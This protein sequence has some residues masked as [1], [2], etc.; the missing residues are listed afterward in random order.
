[1]KMRAWLVLVIAIALAGSACSADSATEGSA[2]LAAGQDA[3]ATNVKVEDALEP[4][5]V[6]MTAVLFDG[7]ADEFQH[8]HR[9]VAGHG[10]SIRDGQVRGVVIVGGEPTDDE[11]RSW[12]GAL[13]NVVTRAEL[14]V[15]LSAEDESG[16][17]ADCAL[18]GGAYP[19]TIT[20]GLDQFDI[21]RGFARGL[22][23]EFGDVHRS[24]LRSAGFETLGESLHASIT[25]K[26]D[27]TDAELASWCAKLRNEISRA[28]VLITV[29]L[30]AND[31]SRNKASC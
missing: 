9:E 14:D 1:M 18:D 16:N 22:V 13:G 19:T 12:C 24:E 26:G 15:V 7:L 27:R 2:V 30:E 28:P 29:A 20:T 21:D 31:Q 25:L 3:T 11:L 5:D 17:E 8:A 23:H 4:A 10:Y 6:Q